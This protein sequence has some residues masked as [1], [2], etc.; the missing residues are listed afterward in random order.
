MFS[1]L[2]FLSMKPTGQTF[3]CIYYNLGPNAVRL[4]ILKVTS[5]QKELCLYNIISDQPR[6][7]VVRVS[8]Y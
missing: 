8:D 1:P 5:Y 7:L 2:I 6:G 3:A 4:T